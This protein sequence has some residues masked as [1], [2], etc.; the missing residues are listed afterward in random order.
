MSKIGIIAGGGSLPLFIG[1]NLL[2]NNYPVCFFYIKNFADPKLYVNYECNEIE[3]TS[4]TKILDSLKKNKISQIVM[5]GKI[6]RPSIKDIKF[7][8]NT[9]KIIKEFFLES[10]GDDDILKFISKLFLNKGFPLFDW[11]NVCK[12]LFTNKDHLTSKRPSKYANQNKEK[13]LDIFKIIGK[14]DIGQS[15]IIQN[16]LIL[17]I[18]GIEG[19]DELIKRCNQYKKIGD[20]GILL[21]LSKSKQHNFLDLPTI[22]FETVKNIKNYNYEGLFIEK[23]HCIIIEKEVVIDFCNNNDL[24]LSTIEKID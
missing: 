24:F 20:K 11:K 21:K 13:G 23:N 10:K 3:L 5:A 4:L 18:E 9:I 15:I 7:D 1:K 17:G 22:G 14:A 8:F 19:T 16:Q 2:K 12:D 6:V